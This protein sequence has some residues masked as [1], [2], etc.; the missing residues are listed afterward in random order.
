L[1]VCRTLRL[2]ADA[3]WLALATGALQELCEAENFE[4]YGSVTPDDAAEFFRDRVYEFGQGGWCMIGM[5]VPYVTGDVPAGCLPCDGG[6]YQRVD[7]PI[8]YEVIDP[9]FIIDADHFK[10]PDLQSRSVR[11]AAENPPAGV[12]ATGG[13]DTATIS[14]ANLPNI[15]LTDAG[16]GHS[17]LPH[18]HGYVGAVE[19]IDV[20][21]EIPL[22]GALATPLITAPAT[23]TILT[24][25]ANVSLGGGGQAL[26]IANPFLRLR[27][28]VVAA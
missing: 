1:T 25:Y 16:H 24:G 19:V 10:T 3:S 8:L 20:V 12:G 11:G 13:A 21:G 28:C 27:F 7:Y 23:S 14:Q 17:A 18:E 15:S 6:T 5:V 22:P 26:A 2:P 9:V 4:H